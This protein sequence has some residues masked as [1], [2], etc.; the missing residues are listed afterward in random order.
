MTISVLHNSPCVG[1]SS[2]GLGQVA[3][4]LAVAQSQTECFVKV[5]CQ[6]TAED[7]DWACKFS[8]ISKNRI[9]SFRSGS[10]KRL[11]YSP[12]MIS[13]AKV[14][15]D[16]FDIIHQH[17]IWTACSMVSNVFRKRYGIPVVIA[18]HGALHK[19]ALQRSSW[20]KKI[21]LFA[22]E[23]EN[24][25]N[26]ACLH[27]TAEAEIDFFRN[28][29]LRNPIALIENGVSMN[30]LEGV[31]NA[32]RFIE[33][34]N[35]PG[36]RR[37]LLFLSRITPQKGLP[38]MLKAIN[39]I[40]NEFSNWLFVIGGTDEFNHKKEIESLVKKLNLQDMV[41]IVE[42][43]YDQIKLDAFAASDAFALPSY[44][45]GAPMVI[46]DSLAAGVPVMTTKGNSWQKLTT[47][48]CGW[49]ADA[50]VDGLV[51]A[52]R[53]VIALNPLQLKDMG[54]RGKE[55]VRSQYLWS[56]QAQK[57]HDLYSWLLGRR[58]KPDFVITD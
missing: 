33:R 35:L 39:L 29:G 23:N 36:D 11:F 9:V 34:F 17:S 37:I 53:S 52:L 31:G 4:N 43:L 56:V 1:K 27:A 20:K 13:A 30:A 40:R 7:I 54:K 58:S 21:A 8:R 6:D 5:W 2:F 26:A 44:S 22:Y 47:Y 57:T 42:P 28:F 12:R 10:I 14:N 41:H 15:T 18:P 50:S 46:L 3:L 48:Q 24:L 51:D 19:W 25:Q 38:I 32:K 16:H 45:E 49:W 55:L